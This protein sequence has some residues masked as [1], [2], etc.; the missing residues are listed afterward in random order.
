M[1]TAEKPS[2]STHQANLADFNDLDI[3][4][5]GFLERME[6]ASELAATE[7]T[8]LNDAY[9]NSSEDEFNEIVEDL[10]YD[11]MEDDPEY[12]SIRGKLKSGV[13]DPHLNVRV[14]E[15][16]EHYKKIIIEEAGLPDEAR[17]TEI[18]NAKNSVQQLLAER[19]NG[20]LTDP[21]SAI[22]ALDIFIEEEG[23][24]K[25]RFPNEI[26]PQSVNEKWNTY[27][28]TV[29]AHVKSVE[30]LA[31]TGDQGRVVSAD[32]SRKYA[33]DS[34]TTDVHAVLGLEGLKDWQF[35]D[36]RRLLASIRDEVFPTLGSVKSTPSE[37]ALADDILS[38]NQAGLRVAHKLST[39]H[40]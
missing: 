29:C 3:D 2:S 36:T 21:H 20:P 35:A 40:K 14:R 6:K 27:L 26:M 18:E 39:K 31:I 34:V 16:A 8:R 30:E 4:I 38:H 5:S 22:E 33:H 17:F 1:A 15:I 32:A 7:S 24:K 28:A 9:K 19:L 25:Y 13:Q 10:A 37:E 23:V 12:V 11:L